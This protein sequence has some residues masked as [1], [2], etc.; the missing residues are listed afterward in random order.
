MQVMSPHLATG[1]RAAAWR[2]PARDRRE[3]RE[4]AIEPKAGTVS[5]FRRACFIIAA[6]LLAILLVPVLFLQSF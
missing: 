5:S 1:L 4:G 2:K 6:W 3:G